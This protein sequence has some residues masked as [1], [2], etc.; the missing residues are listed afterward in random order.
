MIKEDCHTSVAD[1]IRSME[2]VKE[3]LESDPATKSQAIFLHDVGKKLKED[4]EGSKIIQQ[5]PGFE[6]INRALTAEK[7]PKKDV[8]Y[9]LGNLQYHDGINVVPVSKSDK[10][11]LLAQFN[12]FNKSYKDHLDEY[13]SPLEDVPKNLLILK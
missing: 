2:E 4:T 1:V 5:F 3:K 11:V 10:E 13:L 6:G 7:Y 9:V 8:N 12:Q